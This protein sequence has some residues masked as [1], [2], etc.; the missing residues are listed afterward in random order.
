MPYIDFAALATGYLAV[1]SSYHV[2]T[3]LLSFAA[4]DMALRFY[5]GAYGCNPIEHRHLL[6]ILRPWG[7]LAVFAGLAGF[8]ALGCPPART[9]IEAALLILLGMRV[10]YRLGLRREL[11]EISGIPPRHNFANIGLLLI[12]IILLATDLLT[13]GLP[14][15]L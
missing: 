1:L 11:A 8:V 7:A 4:P 9:W 13:R 5:R 6:I 3:G 12:G 10:I 15:T 14:G 2:A